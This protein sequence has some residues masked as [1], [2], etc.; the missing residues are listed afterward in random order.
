MPACEVLF[1]PRP[2]VVLSSDSPKTLKSPSRTF[3]ATKS[4]HVHFGGKHPPAALHRKQ[5]S[6]IYNRAAAVSPARS[7][8]YNRSRDSPA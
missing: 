1:Q 6:E 4:E 7:N 3:S 8:I 5:H 2:V